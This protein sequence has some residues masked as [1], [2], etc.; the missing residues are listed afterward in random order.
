MRRGLQRKNKSS[1]A[2]TAEQRANDPYDIGMIPSHKLEVKFRALVEQSVD[3]I[4]QVRQIQGGP[5]LYEYV[6][7]SSAEVLGW[8]AQEM[9]H[10]THDM[11]YPPAS[12]VVIREAGRRLVEGAPTTIV[13]VE[14][15]RKDGRHIWLE[16]RVRVLTDEGAGNR[17]VVVCMR[18]ITERKLLEDKLAHLM[19]MDALTGIGNRRAFDAALEREWTRAGQTNSPLSLVM[20]DV[21]HFKKLNDTFGHQRGDQCLCRIAGEVNRLGQERR[22][23][24][25]RYGGEELAMLLP[26]IGSAQAESVARELC[27][28][29]KALNMSNPGPE[30]SSVV[31]VSCGV[32]TYYAGTR[33]AETLQATELLGEADRALYQAKKNG[34]NRAEI[35]PT[36]WERSRGQYDRDDAKVSGSIDTH[37]RWSYRVAS[38]S[39]RL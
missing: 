12:M 11:V 18:D 5:M 21:D 20:V 9:R 6:S 16:N 28:R 10:V 35:A 29:I 26:N 27:R 38:P 4:C 7:P 36:L 37:R 23:F 17:T 19:M 15:I 34:R 25:A 13:T 31:T 2:H 1:H 8:T 22:A 3:M 14:A 39:K 33:G 30:Q 24:V 32:A